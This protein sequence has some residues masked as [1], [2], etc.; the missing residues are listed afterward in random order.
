MGQRLILTQ[1]SGWE[2][3]LKRQQPN[4]HMLDEAAIMST[5]A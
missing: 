4:G 2:I 3:K 1:G 5:A